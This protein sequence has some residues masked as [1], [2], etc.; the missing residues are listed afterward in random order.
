MTFL[1]E[2]CVWVL[3]TLRLFRRGCLANYEVLHLCVLKVLSL[4]S[5]QKKLSVKLKLS[6]NLNYGFNVDLIFAHNL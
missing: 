1:Q 3:S 2:M 6:L 5:R 4:W